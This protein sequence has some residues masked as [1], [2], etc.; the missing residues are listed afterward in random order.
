MTARALERTPIEAAPQIDWL[1]AVQTVLVS[2]ALDDLEET[3]LLPERKILYQF[4]ARGHDVSQSILAQMLTGARDAA[5]VYYRSRPL[6][7]ALGLRWEDAVG[8]TMMR[9]GGVSEGRDI[10]VFLNLQSR[11]GA[12][13][14]PACG[15]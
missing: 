2:R 9:A 1:R 14:L 8:S 13:V 4:T 10:G 7:L 11:S 15:G 6:V 12:C 5:S 3:R